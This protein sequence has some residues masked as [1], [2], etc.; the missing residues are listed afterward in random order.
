M[1]ERVELEALVGHVLAGGDAG[2]QLEAL[3]EL[4]AA[5][6][7]LESGLAADAIR[8]GLSWRQIGAAL[9]IS[10]QAAHRRHRDAVTRALSDPE[11]GGAGSGGGAGCAVRVSIPVR[12][13]VRLARQ[14]AAVLGSSV[15]R[16]EHLL[17]GVLRCGDERAVR[18]FERIEVTPEQAR[19]ALRHR[20]GRDGAPRPDAAQL[21]EL[22]GQPEVPA[23]SAG[24]VSPLA[25]RLFERALAEVAVRNGEELTA[26]D[27][28]HALISNETS[29]AARTLARL[30]VAP[31]R[32][33]AELGALQDRRY[34]C[35]GS[36]PGDD[37]LRRGRIV[38][39][40]ASRGS[41]EAS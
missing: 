35:Q 5:L 11:P 37:R 2:R 16:T 28:L 13:A 31:E 26:L 25:R 34:H 38:G 7:E 6:D 41:R 15:L 21:T 9:G 14:E 27:L 33:R 8:A 24:A 30:G 10:K 3:R 18:L 20:G 12:R 32:V 39:V 4:R 40:V 22:A 36:T 1:R 29:G 19:H 23:G 17:L